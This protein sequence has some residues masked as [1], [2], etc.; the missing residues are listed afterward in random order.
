[1]PQPA[2][3]LEIAQI[4]QHARDPGHPVGYNLLHLAVQS[5]SQPTTAKVFSEEDAD[6]SLVDIAGDL[7]CLSSHIMMLLSSLETTFIMFGDHHSD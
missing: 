3:W 1:M 6:L 7:V 4:R 5:G 2:W